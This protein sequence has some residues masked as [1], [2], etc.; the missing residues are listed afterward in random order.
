MWIIRCAITTTAVLAWT[1]TAEARPTLSDIATCNQEATS[2]SPSAS[3]GPQ[4][5]PLAQ[6]PRAAAP[7]VPGGKTDPSGSIIVEADD[8]LL[9]GMDAGRAS[10]PAYRAAYRQCM[11]KQMQR[12]PR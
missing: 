12:T 9:E 1:T 2:G 5:R 4:D 11:K 10:D 8:P 6:A 7:S 3:P